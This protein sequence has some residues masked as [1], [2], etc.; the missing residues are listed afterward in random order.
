ME[1]LLLIALLFCFCACSGPGSEKFPVNTRLKQDNIPSQYFDIDTRRDTTLKTK[2]GAT[3]FIPK[4]AIAV[5]DKRTSIKLE[6]KEAYTIEDILKAG[7]RTK[8]GTQ[9]LSSGGMLYLNA[10]DATIKKGISVSIPSKN[11]KTGM[12]LFEGKPT[13]DGSIDWQNP[14]P[15]VQN[16]FADSIAVG[17]SIF[18]NN[19]ASCHHPA[20]NATG[21]PLAFIPQRRDKKWLKKFI[22]NSAALIASGDLLANCIYNE[23]NKTAMTAFPNLTDADLNALYAFL[24]E[25]S[26]KL[27]PADYPDYNQSLDSCNTYYMAKRALETQLNALKQKS[28]AEATLEQNNIPNTVN[29]PEGIEV[30]VP[31]MKDNMVVPKIETA[32]DYQFTINTFG[33]YNVDIFIDELPDFMNSNLKVRINNRLEPMYNVYLILP[34]DMICTNGGFMKDSKE[35]YAFFTDDGKIKLPQQKQAYLLAFCEQDGKISF[36]LEPFKTN[37]DNTITLNASL[38]TQAE[39][40]EHLKMLDFK[41]FSAEVKENTN[42]RDIKQLRVNLENVEKLKP[43]NSNCSCYAKE[44]PEVFSD[45]AITRE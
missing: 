15:A 33:W 20:K 27:D 41:G 17:K 43:K 32:T 25:E 5:K 31:V 16:S 35:W 1:K 12:Q 24:N 3:I 21:P 22:Y 40:T 7:L 36:A 19:C 29:I 30:S 18:N 44:E 26:K 34:E 4:E 6:L 14:N 39:M 11:V 2:G 9:V 8:S 10:A 38:I 23:W 42:T 45:S 13:E 28:G 37:I